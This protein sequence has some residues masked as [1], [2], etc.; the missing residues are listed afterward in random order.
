MSWQEEMEELARRKA[1]AA[2]MGGAR[3]GYRP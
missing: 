3:I 2:E 1:R